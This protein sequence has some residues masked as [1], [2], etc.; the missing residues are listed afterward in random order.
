MS[1]I[2]RITTDDLRQMSDSEGIIFQGCGGNLQEW[3]D[4]I[5]RTFTQA[6]I[7]RDG[8][9]FSADDVFAFNSDKLTCLL[10]RFNSDLNLNM[11]KLAMWRLQTHE[12]FGGTWLSD[13]V[14]NHL[15]GFLTDHHPQQKPD[16][17]LLGADGNIFDLIGIA[18]RTL[19]ENGM[20]SEAKEM[21]DRITSSGS[22]DEALSII[23]EYVNITE[24]DDPVDAENMGGME[25]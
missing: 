11:G 24:V 12:N 19:K 5:N 14:P 25:L 21:C 4:G 17:P 10:F 20:K 8:S 7:L 6:E 2:K 22:Y 13:Y 16:C 23:G 1:E 15:G 18:N 9:E 3:L